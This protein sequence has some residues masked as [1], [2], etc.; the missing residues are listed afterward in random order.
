VNIK[1]ILALAFIL[2]IIISPYGSHPIDVPDWIGWSNRLVEVPFNKFYDAWSDYL[3]GYLY[4]LWILGLVKNFLITIGI[5]LK[6]DIIFKLPAIAADIATGLL[7]FTITKKYFNKKRAAIF[8]SLY[9]FNPAIF[10]NSA[11]WG[12]VDSLT[13]F[14][15]LLLGKTSRAFNW[16]FDSFGLIKKRGF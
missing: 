16:P 13:A 11:L 1:I 8:A 12:Q 4:V 15:S 14:S 5:T 10:Y 9:L 6:E 2:R 3:P 7:I